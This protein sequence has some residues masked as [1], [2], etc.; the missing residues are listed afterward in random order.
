MNKSLKEF[1]FIFLISIFLSFIRLQFLDDGFQ[2]LNKSSNSQAYN[3]TADSFSYYIDLENPEVLTIDKAKEI[4]EENFTVFID[5]REYSDFIDGHILNAIHVPFSEN[6][7]YDSTLIDSLYN[8]MSFPQP[9][10]SD[11]C[12]SSEPFGFHKGPLG[13]GGECHK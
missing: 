5:A 3:L 11:R 4:Y 9:D 13:I 8:L 12:H 1:L 2:L 7:K 10:V 6:D